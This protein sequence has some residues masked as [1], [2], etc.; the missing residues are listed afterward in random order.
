MN[1]DHQRSLFEAENEVGSVN[2]FSP[3]AFPQSFSSNPIPLPEN[4]IYNA[5][6]CTRIHQSVTYLNDNNQSRWHPGLDG[7]WKFSSSMDW[8]DALYHTYLEPEH[9]KHNH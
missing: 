8:A 3:G 7:Y 5:Y 2:S 6:R 1:L 9:G 4:I